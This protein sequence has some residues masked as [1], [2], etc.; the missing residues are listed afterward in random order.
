MKVRYDATTV[1]Y[2]T[3]CMCVCAC[4]SVY[5]CVYVCVC[6]CM[7]M[8]AYVCMCVH[9]FICLSPLVMIFLRH[10]GRGGMTS[11]RIGEGRRS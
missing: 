9:V 7:Y 1:A 10:S 8:C 3:V 4:V 6:M 11:G 5:V 2:L